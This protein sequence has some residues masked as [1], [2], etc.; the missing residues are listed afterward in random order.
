MK[1]L[2]GILVQNVD[3]NSS[4]MGIIF[5]K[6]Q[7]RMRPSRFGYFRETTLKRAY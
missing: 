2:N 7:V 6:L 3:G 4:I 1:A 5:W